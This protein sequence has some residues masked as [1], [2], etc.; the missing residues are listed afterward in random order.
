MAYALLDGDGHGQVSVSRL[1]E[2]FE[3]ASLELVLEQVDFELF[4]VLED[5]VEVVPFEV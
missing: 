4:L 3:A 5:E 2:A 1:V